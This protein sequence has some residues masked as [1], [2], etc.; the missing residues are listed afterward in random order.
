ISARL[1]LSAAWSLQVAAT[2]LDAHFTDGFGQV[3]A[4]AAIPGVARRQ[5]WARLQWRGQAWG[6]AD[7][8][9]ALGGGPVND[10]GTESAPGRGPPAAA[11]GCVPSPGSTTC[12]RASTQAR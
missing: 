1:P 9:L 3:A 11:S 4:G 10:A 6:A 8:G 12:T 7:E 5:G 2:W